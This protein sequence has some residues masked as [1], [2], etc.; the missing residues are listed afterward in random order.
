[1]I[2]MMLSSNAVHRGYP[3]HYPAFIQFSWLK[4]S[5]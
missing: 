1:M 4:C 3:L 5:L 2:P